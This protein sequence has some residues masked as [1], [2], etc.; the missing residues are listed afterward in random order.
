MSYRSLLALGA[1]AALGASLLA[2]CATKPAPQPAPQAAA[3]APT[4]APSTPAPAA[5][6]ASA[7]TG[8][9]PGSEADFLASAGGDRVYF[10]YDQTTVRADA[11][12]V[13]NAQAAWLSRYPS[14]TIQVQGNA[15]ERG[16]REYNIALGARRAQAVRD[17]LMAHGVAG[18]RLTTISFGKE[19]P[20]DLGNDETAW[21]HNRNAHTALTGGTR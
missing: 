19:H 12:P 7:P 3:P 18:A 13:L 6:V 16:T 20:V 9:V 11:A 17:Y 4:P 21:A 1:A 8:P 10:D 5:P 2:G 14:V 15:D